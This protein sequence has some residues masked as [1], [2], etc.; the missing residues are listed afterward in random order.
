MMIDRIM[1]AFTFRKGIYAES[2]R[3][4]GF[5][6]DAWI[7]VVVVTFL[8][9][10]GASASV[11]STNQGF[12]SFLISVIVGTVVGLIGFVIS[13]FLISWLSRAMFNAKAGFDELQRAM[14]LASVWRV[15][16]FLSILG[17]ISPAL[18]CLVSPVTIIAG[19][20]GLVAF[21]F[22]I[23]EATGMDTV[24]VIVTVVVAL[25]VQLIVTA[26]VSGI[27]AIFG[28]G[29]AALLGGL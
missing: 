26:V 7:I 2:A 21:F 13:V 20:A 14:G 29:A 6:T 23:R 24:G 10:L 15:I 9:Q 22:A 19:I 1:G 3:E 11:L 28:I 12:G 25:V 27:L 4:T 8:A 17:A 5:T 18:V 16:G